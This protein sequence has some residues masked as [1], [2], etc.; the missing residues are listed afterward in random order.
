[1]EDYRGMYAERDID[2]F[3]RVVI[4]FSLTK[5]FY[6]DAYSILSRYDKGY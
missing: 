1:M 4:P 2:N 3:S 6:G 5:Y